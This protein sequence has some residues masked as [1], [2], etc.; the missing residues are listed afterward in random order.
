M[1]YLSDRFSF[2]GWAVTRFRLPGNVISPLHF[3]FLCALQFSQKHNKH[4]LDIVIY[5]TPERPTY[6]G[7]NTY[8]FFDR[9]VGLGVSH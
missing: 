6:V 9:L 3:E 4:K 2:C 8:I 5:L 1:L 7:L